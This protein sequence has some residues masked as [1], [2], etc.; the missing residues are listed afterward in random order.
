MQILGDIVIIGE[1][2]EHVNRI[3]VVSTGLEIQPA[4]RSISGKIT[5]RCNVGVGGVTM[6][7]S[8]GSDFTSRD[9]TTSA[10]GTYTFVNIPIGRTY[11]VTPKLANMTFNPESPGSET[12][13]L[14]GTRTNVNFSAD[15]SVLVI[16]GKIEDQE[17]KPVP[18]LSVSLTPAGLVEKDVK[19]NEAGVFRF[20]IPGSKVKLPAATY[21]I[22][23]KSDK[24]TFD[25][26][27]K[28]WTCDE[29]NVNFVATA[30]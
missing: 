9:V 16:T 30:K 20:E 6:T 12:F 26:A 3:R 22:T 18:N 19:T 14:N 5:D 4:D 15:Y 28:T 29:R 21:Q 25:A 11:T 8:S 10:D 23:P 17:S 13:T 27:T 24:Y 1:Q 2:I 7:I